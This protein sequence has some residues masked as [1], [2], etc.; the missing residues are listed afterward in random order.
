M[1]TSYSDT[2]RA[3]VPSL[4]QPPVGP[5]V[6][7]SRAASAAGRTDRVVPCIHCGEATALPASFPAEQLVFCCHGCRGAYELI[8]GWGLQD[9]YALR[10]QTRQHSGAALPAEQ[11]GRYEQF[12]TV[13]FLGPS[14]PRTHSD[15]TCTT[16]LAVHGLH[17]SACAWLIEKAAA[18]S[19]GLL[20]ARIK[21]NQHTLQL[22]YDPGAIK[23]SQIAQLLDRLGY[24]LSPFDPSRQDH[25]QHE[26][27]RLLVQ[28][29]IAGFLA[30]NAMWIA[31]GLYAGEFGGGSFDQSYFL[32]LVGTALGVASVAGPGRTFF[33]GALASL[34]TRT[35]H[36]DLPVALGLSV[37]T[38]VG[39]THAIL[40]RGHVYFDS[41][42]TLV[43]LLLIGRWIQ[44]R[45]QQRAMRAVDLLLR[46]TPRH[47][48]LESSAD[49]DQVKSVLVETLLPGD[50]VRVAAGDS[51]PAD[52]H[53]VSGQTTLDRSLLTG[54]S[55]PVPVGVGE[56]VSAG[57]I[58]LTTPI[59]VRVSAIG[60]E[61]RLGKVMQSVETAAAQR[62]PIVM[63][64]DRIGG[65]FVIAITLLA[66]VTFGLWLPTSLALATSHAT[67]L[68]IVACP[69]ALAL[70][71]PLAIAVGLGRAARRN[72]MIRDGQTFQR[73][74]KPGRI[75]LD[76][77]GTLT[78]GKQHITALAGSEE[79][80]RMAASLEKHCKHPVA[81]AIV[82]A[83]RQRHLATSGAAH[84]GG[85]ELGG[86]QGE[87][88]GSSVLVGSVDFVRRAEIAIPTAMLEHAT[89]YAAQGMSPNLIAV[90]RQVVTVL[91][92]S[93]PIRPDAS[94]VIEQ[95]AKLGWKVGILS[96]DH[97]SIVRRIGEQLGLA[98]NDCHGGLSPEQKL[99][100]IRESQAVGENVAMV[101]DGA[102]DAA[103][104]AAADT[105]IAVRGGAEVSLQAAPVF[106][107]SGRLP[108][109]LTLLVGA[110]RTT[111]LIF[112]TFAISLT[113]NLVAV[114]LAMLGWISPLV[115]A[116]LMPLS[117]V[118]V[119]ALT[120][121]MK[122][123]VEAEP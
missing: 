97:P 53:I 51:L 16:E 113:Y 50:I 25:L 65:Y 67:A 9:F 64:A 112:L 105:G 19:P 24:Q 58:N 84:L 26:N 32:G 31:I 104:L 81:N 55:Q 108:S 78:Q 4:Q 33:V 82:Q 13:D 68:L 69:C 96:G 5:E 114:G 57:L 23:L 71:T 45:Q 85:A 49:S 2:E 35:P 34:K 83:A 91:G 109:L 17:C 110:R 87:V 92:L 60:R 30:A 116:I 1:T 28:I 11:M 123:F 18:Q 3:A 52:G 94:R 22:A 61:S 89:E 86:I 79:G 117:S 12:D 10:D 21:M 74:A 122:T 62:T 39:I 27:R 46:I 120:L 20:S 99:S 72:I 88:D 102:N 54:E 75:W 101:G 66:V 41:L 119:L 76:K 93:D 63:L 48:E 56:E 98:T 36:M 14:A 100:Y 80:L 90:D 15:G 121:A 107:A 111:H 37:G 95:L 42:A 7:T 47:A 118:S 43:F 73:L 29:A 44:F 103:A 40:G 59:R 6:A 8:H 106:I 77:T 115:A 38:V 70:A